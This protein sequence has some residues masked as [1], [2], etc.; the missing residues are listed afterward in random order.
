LF[1][2]NGAFYRVGR[3]G[4]AHHLFITTAPKFR[5]RGQP[6]REPLAG[7]VPAI[8]VDVPGLAKQRFGAR[9]GADKR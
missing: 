7:C 2:P 6:R 4:T 9:A 5:G 3:D 8:D 1:R